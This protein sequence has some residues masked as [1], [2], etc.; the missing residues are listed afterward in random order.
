M[1]QFNN[2]IYF[3]IIPLDIINL[4]AFKVNIMNSLSKQLITDN[5][6]MRQKLFQIQRLL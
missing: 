4:N 3:F 2:T 1:Y 5:K 6:D